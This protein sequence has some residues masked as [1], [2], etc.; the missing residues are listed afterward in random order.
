MWRPRSLA[1]WSPPASSPP[2]APCPPPPAPAT[3]PR[4]PGIKPAT[5]RPSSPSHCSAY[6]RAEGSIRAFTAGRAVVASAFDCARA[7]A[8]DEL[9]GQQEIGR[10]QRETR[11]DDT[12]EDLTQLASGP[13]FK[14]AE[15][16]RN[17]LAIGTP[18][19]V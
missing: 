15:E 3:C 9:F 13:F 11:Q 7:Q 1:P 14:S 4:Q 17:R 19:E 16:V 6:S 5:W 12:G 8:G 18:D 2:P 10:D